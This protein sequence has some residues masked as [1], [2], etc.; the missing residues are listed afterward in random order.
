MMD[1]SDFHHFSEG[2]G[3]AFLGLEAMPLWQLETLFR[4]TPRVISHMLP[5]ALLTLD[6]KLKDRI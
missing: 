6:V 2:Q 4:T 3:I 1:E 5:G